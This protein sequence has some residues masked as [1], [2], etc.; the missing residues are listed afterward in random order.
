MN[1]NDIIALAKQGYKPGDIKELIALADDKTEPQPQP[2][3][4]ETENEVPPT[5]ADGA[6]DP[7][8]GSPAEAEPSIDYKA[9]YEE[10]QK[11]LKAAQSANLNQ[12]MSEPN[13]KSDTD[14]L[15]EWARS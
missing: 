13:K 3:P 9:L 15:L 4:T 6:P 10:S 11:Q 1:L 14:I 8:V 7:N 12:N 2:T 5:E